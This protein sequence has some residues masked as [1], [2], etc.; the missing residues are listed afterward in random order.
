MEDFERL[1]EFFIQRPLNHPKRQI[2]S[3]FYGILE[4]PENLL[5]FWIDWLLILLVGLCYKDFTV[6]RCYRLGSGKRVLGRTNE[7]EAL[8]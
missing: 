8:V 3:S 6:A 7:T 5:I 2:S 4:L 1:K